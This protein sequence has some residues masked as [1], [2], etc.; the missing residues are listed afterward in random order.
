MRRSRPPRLLGVC[1]AL[2]FACAGCARTAPDG[3]PGAGGAPA[4]TVRFAIA[5]D[6]GSL[7][8]LFAHVDANSVE[9]QVAR[10]A[11]E[12]FIDVDERGTPVPVLLDR[13]PTV[14]NG[15]VSHDGRVITYHLRGGVRWQD[16]VPVTA[17]DVVWTLHA[18]LDDRNAV[19]SRAGYDRVA[20]ADALSDRVVRVRL[21]EPWAPAV[22]TLFSYGTAPQYVLPAHLLEKEANLEQSAFSSHPVGNGPYR[23]V[24]WARGDHLVYEAN[25]SYWRGAPKVA[26]L[27]IRVVPDP[28]TNFTLLQSGALDWNLMSP[29]QRASLGKPA[30]LDFRTVPLALVAGI[31]INTAHPPLDDARVRRAIAASIDRDGISKKITFGRYPVVDTAQALGS[32]ARDPAVREPAYDPAAADRLL[33]AAGWKRGAGGV[34]AKDGK[35]LALTYVQFPESATGVRVATLVQSELGARGFRITVKALS[36]AQLFLPK[37]QGGT[38]ANGGFDM[39]YVPWPMGADPD[40]S[41]LL[42]CSGSGNYMRWCDK[43]ADALEK[44]AVVAPSRAERARLYSQIER[45]VADQVPV[46]YL[47][48]PSYSYAYRTALRGFYPNAFSPT[49]DAYRWS[50]SR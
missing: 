6:P 15:G 17:R 31:A 5:A 14:E 3:E 41:F 24:S 35:E 43:E 18:I 46:V 38:L 25:P 21:K 12:P 37:S 42:A 20:R 23:F 1:A 10:L 7:N 30:Q 49:W 40:D 28:G 11:F 33:D 13:V 45:R 16:G 19:R 8:P 32:W 22:A 47:F 50:L 34:R 44:R 39:A 9:Q 48:N 29:A 26:R 4:S 36:N 27:S 2:A